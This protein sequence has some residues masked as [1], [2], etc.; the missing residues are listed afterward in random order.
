MAEEL[1]EESTQIEGKEKGQIRNNNVDEKVYSG[2]EKTFERLEPGKGICT[3]P[4]GIEYPIMYKD[5]LAG[6][7][8][9]SWELENLTRILTP[10]VPTLDKLFL[11]LKAFFVPLTRVWGNAEKAL[12]GKGEAGVGNTTIG[13]QLTNLPT[14]LLNPDTT[15]NP[16][17]K[18]SVLQALGIPYLIG[19]DTT[20]DITKLRMYRA[21]INDHLRNKEYEVAHPEFNQDTP[22]NIEFNQI[23]RPAN[24]PNA[25]LPGDPDRYSLYPSQTRKNYLTNIK[26]HMTSEQVAMQG[27]VV[28]PTH[29]DWQ[30]QYQDLKQRQLNAT[31][32]DWDII[33]E[34][35]GTR[36]VTADRT[37]FLG[38]IDYEINYQQIGQTSATQQSPN[39]PLGTT[40]SFSYT[41]IEGE[42][43]SHKHFQQHGTVIVLAS[44]N[45]EK[46]YEDGIP[47]E[48]LKTKVND[49]YR[50]GL[51]KKEVQLLL[52]KEITGTEAN[53][54]SVAYQPAWA[55]YKRMPNLVTA[56]AR[57]TQ[58]PDLFGILGPQS[59]SQW[60]N[61]I[62]TSTRETGGNITIDRN[63]F[64]N[65]DEVRA[66]T[67]RNNAIIIEDNINFF[68]DNILNMSVHNIETSLPIREEDLKQRERASKTR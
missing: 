44:I 6:E 31:K 29:L 9:R 26:R 20:I 58:P 49:I 33:A 46:V 64:N 38:S 17:F 52:A 14:V 40:G 16:H 12:A 7:Y 66:V 67:N 54:R 42:L 3:L 45:I 63:Y 27:G 61:A 21:I 32:N 15:R 11:T 10:L 53:G 65:R 50:P 2:R 13:S 37:E 23:N 18:F 62:P 22:T 34:M 4:V 8:I 39:S 41:R 5:V 47:K 30:S 19:T 36:P 59:Y 35:G 60:H 25:F 56:G 57:T 51:G 68:Q 28:Q 1:K 43:F 48:L 55:E 24:V